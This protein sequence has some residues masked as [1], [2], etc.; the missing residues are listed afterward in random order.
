MWGRRTSHKAADRIVQFTI[1]S[2]GAHLPLIYVPPGS[3]ASFLPPQAIPLQKKTRFS[4]SV[5]IRMMLLSRLSLAEDQAKR[6]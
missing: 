4:R 5:I 6:A 2:A 1:T 3:P